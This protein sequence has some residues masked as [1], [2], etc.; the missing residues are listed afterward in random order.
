MSV[1]LAPIIR[2]RHFLVPWRYSPVHVP[3]PVMRAKKLDCGAV[4]STPL[5]LDILADHRRRENSPAMVAFGVGGSRRVPVC[6]RMYAR[7]PLIQRIWAPNL[8][9]I[10]LSG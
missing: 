6:W 10:C 4:G 3:L 9:P 7:V 8:A 2:I 1:I 5:A